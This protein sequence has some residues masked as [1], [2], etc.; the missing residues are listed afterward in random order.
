MARLQSKI[1][2]IHQFRQRIRG[3]ETF[4]I[5]ARQ[6]LV[7]R[8]IDVQA[9]HVTN[10][11]RTEQGQA[12]T[13]GIADHQIHLLGGRQPF[14]HHLHRLFVQG[15]LQAVGDEARRI[16]NPRRDLAHRTNQGLERID[17]LR[18]CVQA[19][20]QLNARNERRRVHPVHAQKTL[21]VGDE[22]RQ[23]TNRHRRGVG[24][25]NRVDGTSLGNTAEDIALDV[26]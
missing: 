24:A 5:S 23:L 19:G 3:G 22:F 16:S 21:G 2:G 15:E 10:R 17:M 25:D 6:R 8:G 9:S 12:K 13:E 1:A 18:Q 26:H 7:R 4:A 20:D 11:E 14:F